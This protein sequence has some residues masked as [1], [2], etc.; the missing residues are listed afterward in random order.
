MAKITKTRSNECWEGY[1][2]KRTFHA[3]LVGMQ[4]GVATM[5]NGIEFFP[6]KTNNRIAI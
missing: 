2:G 4:I 5:E 3:M 1:G 6:E